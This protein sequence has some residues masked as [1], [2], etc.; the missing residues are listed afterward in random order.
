VTKDDRPHHAPRA[1][2]VA[3]LPLEAL[4]GR[5]EELASRWTVA[6]ILS[7]PLGALGEISLEELALEAPTLCARA[8]RAL[9]SDAELERL[10]ASAEA[11][12]REELGA[13]RRL[14]ALAGAS[15]AVSVVEAVEA[16]RGVL[17]EA[18]LAELRWP[19]LEQSGTRLLAELADRLAHVCA[20]IL[21]ATV[22]V[23]AADDSKLRGREDTI[24]AGEPAPPGEW[25]EP[26]G[27][28]SS[29]Q[30]VIIDERLAS[31]TP[32]RAATARQATSRSERSWDLARSVP[33]LSPRPEIE[34]RDVRAE[35]GPAAWIRSIGRQLERF[36]QDGRP[37]AVLLI[38]LM[39]SER[40]RREE[41][42]EDLLRLASLLEQAL[43]VEL[44]GSG[45]SLDRSLTREA[46][47]RYWLLAP[48]TD[49][50]RVGALAERLASAVGR[51]TGHRAPA[52]E[53][54]VGTAV[55]P[56][57]GLQAAA[58][59]AHADV[60]LYAARAERSAGGGAAR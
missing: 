29:G 34:I 4:V 16:L 27:R 52:L 50:L 37:F 36:A 45:E 42:A 49:S 41:P 21:A 20:S 26:A 35:E 32:D 24:V 23:I 33:S 46:P 22:A 15:D 8:L 25:P 43:E 47:G 19:L 38:E 5:S 40:L 44:P 1:R 31:E 9:E 13:A 55:C 6:L 14:G 56:E 54:A 58:L 10:T 57:D 60:A 59:A 3:D 18:L 12:G 51:S 30:V 11:T 7:R 2:P 39:D 28:T 48:D 53:I 17:W